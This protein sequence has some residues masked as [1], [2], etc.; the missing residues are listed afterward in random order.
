M[1]CVSQHRVVDECLLVLVLLAAMS[2]V[3]W[4]SVSSGN[5]CSVAG[6]TDAVYKG[7]HP[8]DGPGSVFGFDR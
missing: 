1:S 8:C 5:V 2:L 7:C 3:S 4:W 6:R